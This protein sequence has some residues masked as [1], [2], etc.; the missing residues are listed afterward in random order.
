[1]VFQWLA[2]TVLANPADLFFPMEV[3]SSVGLAVL[4]LVFGSCPCRRDLLSL[5]PPYTS[6]QSMSMGCRLF[7]FAKLEEPV[8]CWDL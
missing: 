5:L 8:L 4:L 1:M 6:S 3:V 2:S 7:F